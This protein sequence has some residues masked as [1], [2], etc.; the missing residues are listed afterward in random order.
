M[1]NEVLHLLKYYTGCSK[2][3]VVNRAIERAQYKT[4]IDLVPRIKHTHSTELA[5][6]GISQNWLFAMHHYR[7]YTLNCS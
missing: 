2:I 6:C 3:T 7:T 4:S 5:V 1:C